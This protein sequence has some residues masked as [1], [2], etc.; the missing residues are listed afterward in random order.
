MAALTEA[1]PG[2]SFHDHDFLADD[3]APEHQE[4]VFEHIPETRGENYNVFFPKSFL[5]EIGD[6]HLFFGAQFV[7]T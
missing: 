2:F 6:R 3:L 7:P 1:Y 4:F 5:S